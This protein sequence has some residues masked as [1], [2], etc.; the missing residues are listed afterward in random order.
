MS[1]ALQK[2][3]GGLIS[4]GNRWA[5]LL[6]DNAAELFVSFA[7]PILESTKL[8]LPE[9]ILD[10]WG[11][12]ISGLR[13]YE[14]VR[15]NGLHF[16]R[17]EIFG[18]DPKGNPQQ[19][20]LRELDLM[21]KYACFAFWERGSEPDTGLLIEAALILNSKVSEPRKM[22]VPAEIK[23]PL[24]N[25]DVSWWQIPPQSTHDFKFD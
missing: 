8:I 2:V 1:I 10:D 24:R 17:A 5:L 11:K 21:S 4:S 12:E 22:Q 18:F 23:V 25:I 15:E 14:W 13:I 9:L 6:D 16:P 3:R 7:Y 19:Y 20:F